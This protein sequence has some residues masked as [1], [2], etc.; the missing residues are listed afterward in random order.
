MAAPAPTARQTP[1]GIWTPSGYRTKYTFAL[2]PDVSLWEV[3][4]KPAGTSVG[5]PIAQD[6]MWNVR[7]KIKRP[8]PLIEGTDASIT[9]LYDPIL[10][11]QIDI[12]VGVETICTE[13]S[14]DGGTKCYYGYL[15][16]VEFDPLELN[17][18]GKGTATIT[19]TDWDYVNR[20]QAGPVFAHIS[21]S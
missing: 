15:A 14:Y 6:S 19:E 13:T 11:S 21:G 10:K 17:Q 2:D 12:M 7:R 8:E 20:V 16:G 3:T 5:Q 9:F 4:V 1:V 18:P